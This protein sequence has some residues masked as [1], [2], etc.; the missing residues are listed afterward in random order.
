ML[1]YMG[2]FAGRAQTFGHP[3][4]L[5]RA[6]RYANGFPCPACTKVQYAKSRRVLSV[7]AAALAK[8]ASEAGCEYAVR[9]DDDPWF[10]T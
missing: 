10:G 3:G 5:A 1:M 4:V 6:C 9:E 8:E 7:L 2:G